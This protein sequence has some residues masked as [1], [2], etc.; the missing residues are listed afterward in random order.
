M[1]LE[2]K[3]R[4]LTSAANKTK[5]KAIRSKLATLFGAEPKKVWNETPLYMVW[6]NVAPST[7]SQKG[8]TIQ[9]FM[10]SSEFAKKVSSALNAQPVLF[11]KQHRT[12]GWYVD[13]CSIKWAGYG[14][15]VELDGDP[16]PFEGPL[17]LVTK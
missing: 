11:S 10:V 6:D 3:S 17:D 7:S 9:D 15:S 1:K 13:G 2:A 8:T 14:R 5:L 16:H 4:L 12:L